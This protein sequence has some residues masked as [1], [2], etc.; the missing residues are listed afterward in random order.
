MYRAKSRIMASF[1][2]F[3][4][5]VLL[6]GLLLAPAGEMV[7]AKGPPAMVEVIVQGQDMSRA[8]AA[9][10]AHGGEVTHKLGIINAV[11]ARVPES[12]L[13]G[14]MKA[15][16]IRAVFPNYPLEIAEGDT[17]TVLDAF[18]TVS[19]SNNDGTAYWK[20]RW[21]ENDVSGPGPAWGNVL[22]TNGKLRLDDS[23]DTGTT[24]GLCSNADP[25]PGCGPVRWKRR[26]F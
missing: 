9:A 18:N 22:V 15:P 21:I 13:K 7:L 24:P 8:A 3:L 1:D 19:Y 4:T 20:D 12:A 5:A 10:Q 2:Q 25:L 6:V 17:W 11:G 26:V 16:G 23:P 14:L